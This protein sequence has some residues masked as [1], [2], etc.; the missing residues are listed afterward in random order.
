MT[1]WNHATELLKQHADSKWHREAAATSAMAHQAESG[2][3]VLELQ[4]SVAAQE[5][6][7]LRQRN[8]DVLLK[9][10]RS[11]YFLVKNRIPHTT[12]RGGSSFSRKGG[13]RYGRGTY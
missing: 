2:Q 13:Q 4:Y 7:E 10:L 9:L 1:D 11:T 6:A 12:I 5:A 3:S 8:R